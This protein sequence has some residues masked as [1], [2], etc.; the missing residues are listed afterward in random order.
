MN[1]PRRRYERRRVIVWRPR[2]KVAV[3]S[4]GTE[5][6][7]LRKVLLREWLHYTMVPPY[8]AAPLDDRAVEAFRDQS[9]N[10]VFA[11]LPMLRPAR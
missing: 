7:G 1:R 11:L 8:I 4:R 5:S 10:A 2:Q 6:R 3:G 9:L